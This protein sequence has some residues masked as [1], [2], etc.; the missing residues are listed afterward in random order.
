M[1]ERFCLAVAGTATDNLFD[2]CSG[3]KGGLRHYEKQ[4]LEPRNELQG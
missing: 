2:G 3:A 1:R 4:A